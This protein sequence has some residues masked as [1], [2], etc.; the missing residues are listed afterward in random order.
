MM[1]PTKQLPGLPSLVLDYFYDYDMVGEFYNGNFRE[2]AAFENLAESVRSRSLPREKL[3]SIL[4]AQNQEYGCGSRTLDHIDSLSDEKTCAVVTGQQVGLFSGPLY[5]I[6]KSLTTIKLAQ[7]LDQTCEGRFVPVFWLASDDHDFEEIN[8]IHVLDKTSQIEK[9]Q[10]SSETSCDKIPASNILLTEDVDRCLQQLDASTHDSDFKQEVLSDLKNAYQSGRSYAR[11]FAMWMT[12]LFKSRGLVFIDASHPDLKALGKH[13]FY[14]EVADESPSTQRALEASKKLQDKNYKN[15]IQLHQGI[16]NVFHSEHERQTIKTDGGNFHI[17]DIERT[18]TK[19]ELLTQVEE[20][21]HLFSPNVLLR[22][23]YQDALLPTVAYVA[24]PGEIAYFAQMKG[25]YEYFGFP[26]PIIY[27]RKTITLLEKK[28]DRVLSR[29]ALHIQ[30]MWRTV[31]RTI[32]EIAQSQIPTSIDNA[33]KAAK[34]H[35]ERN[36]T[37]IKQ[38]AV[39]FEPTLGNAVDVTFGKMNHQFQSLEKKIRQASKRKSALLAQQIQKAH[40]NL[41]PNNRL[42][43]RVLNITPFLIKYSYAL[44]DRL[45]KAVDINCHDHQVVSL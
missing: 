39:A 12:R 24:G 8:H 20:R 7:Y 13:V 28:V 17:R 27:P 4:K 15:Q 44:M 10:C 3:A 2:P 36:F 29:N 19:D 11:A 21:P 5:T 38:E 33:L 14:Q 32:A 1:V 43:E 18:V 34:T 35:L 40:H 23:I 31:D 9:I 41:Y 37:S 45:F 26:M 30:D 25:V 16:L 6:H 22:P 42:Q